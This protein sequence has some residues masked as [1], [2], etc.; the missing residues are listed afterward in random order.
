M[1]RV[2]PWGRRVLPC[3]PASFG[4]P[5]P[6]LH[7]HHHPLDPPSRRV[8]LALGEKGVA[9]ETLLERPW[10][11]RPD[12]LAL[13]PSGAVPVLVMEDESRA[14]VLG[15]A[16]AICEYL[17]ETQPSPSL[18]GADPAV[19]AEVRR[20]VHWFEHRMA[21]EVTQ[22]LLGEKVFKRLHGSGEPNSV[23]LRAGYQNIHAHLDYI[24]WLVDHRNWLA[25]S[26]LSLADLAAA[27]QLSALDYIG[28]VPWDQHVS[29]RDWYGRIKS[30]PAFRSLLGDRLV[31]L[32]P[33]G[34][35]A[36]VDF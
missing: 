25:G 5:M 7:L 23:C 18:L 12:Y 19:R 22:H 21:E 11:P 14:L 15:G 16:D 4:S 26:E 27:A 33:T 24:G 31:G 13:D 32:P 35:Y 17:E 29:A 8:R 20:L 6:S 9:F 28:D 2:V 3:P 34:H 30:R 36:D 1:P 10:A